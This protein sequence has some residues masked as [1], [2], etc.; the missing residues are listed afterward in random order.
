MASDES[1]A[2]FQRL[3]DG[4]AAS[5]RRQMTTE[6][7]GEK[8]RNSALVVMGFLAL[9]WAIRYVAGP[10]SAVRR[11]MDAPRN[12][13][14][15]SE[16]AGSRALSPGIESPETFGQIPSAT[17]LRTPRLDRRGDGEGREGQA[18]TVPLYG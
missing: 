14:T 17:M 7:R 8:L 12:Q 16:P 4:M 5:V 6:R 1:R 18:A 2:L 11:A 13:A 15:A 9:W 10:N 3:V